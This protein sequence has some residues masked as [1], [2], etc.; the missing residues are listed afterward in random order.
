M[1]LPIVIGQAALGLAAI[2][3][4]MLGTRSEPE[5]SEYVN[6]GIMFQPGLESCQQR[7]MAE[8]VYHRYFQHLGCLVAPQ[9]LPL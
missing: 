8:Y 3:A 4:I 1:E 6:V 7:S 5:L 9:T 2:Y